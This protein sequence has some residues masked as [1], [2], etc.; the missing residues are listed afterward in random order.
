M[1]YG[2][3]KVFK[4]WSLK[5]RLRMNSQADAISQVIVYFMGRW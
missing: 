5:L 3:N 4:F 1:M 2:E